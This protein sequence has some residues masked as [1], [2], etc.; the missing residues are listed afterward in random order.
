M[1]EAPLPDA[2]ATALHDTDCYCPSCAETRLQLFVD[3]GSPL[4]ALLN[5]DTPPPLNTMSSGSD[6][7]SS[8]SPVV[9][10]NLPTDPRPFHPRAYLDVSEYTHIESQGHSAPHPLG[11]L[12]FPMILP[13]DIEVQPSWAVIDTSLLSAVNSDTS[14]PDTPE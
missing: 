13:V 12:H 11:Q 14:L 5:L 2:S 9:D 6:D 8:F 1:E 3:D 10:Q 7:W 4:T